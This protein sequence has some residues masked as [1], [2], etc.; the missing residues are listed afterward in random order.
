MG[1][2]KS[3]TGKLGGIFFFH[4]Y[5]VQTEPPPAIRLSPKIVFCLDFDEK[6]SQLRGRGFRMI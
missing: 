1:E 6:T 3:F 5:F 2:M 4:F